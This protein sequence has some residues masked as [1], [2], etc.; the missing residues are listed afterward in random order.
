MYT[1]V[2]IHTHVKLPS[3]PSSVRHWVFPSI[4]TS[5]LLWEK[6]GDCALGERFKWTWQIYE[7]QTGPFVGWPTG[8]LL[9]WQV[10]W[11]YHRWSSSWLGFHKVPSFARLGAFLVPKGHLFF[12]RISSLLPYWFP[13][14]TFISPDPKARASASPTFSLAFTHNNQCSVHFMNFSLKWKLMV[15]KNIDG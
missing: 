15:W 9:V 2:C 13:L 1:Y 6:K 3:S 7:A 4:P 11:L 14:A 10:N 12:L 5:S 8:Q